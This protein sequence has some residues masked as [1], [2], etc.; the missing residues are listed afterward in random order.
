MPMHIATFTTAASVVASLI[1]H[2]MPLGSR[3]SASRAADGRRDTARRRNAVEFDER[4]RD[5]RLEH[6]V[7]ADA[8][9][10]TGEANRQI[11]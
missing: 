9:P 10:L 6:Q 1:T 4:A 2:Y 7:R 3:R 8:A 5:T 11:A